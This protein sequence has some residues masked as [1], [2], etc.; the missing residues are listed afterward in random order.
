M[1]V[2]E[3]ARRQAPFGTPLNGLTGRLS[4]D[5]QRQVHRELGFA[6]IEDGKAVPLPPP[7]TPLAVQ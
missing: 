4:L 2:A 6:R 3:L 1:I 5:A 7:G